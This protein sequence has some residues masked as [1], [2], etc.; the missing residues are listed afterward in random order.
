MKL[1]EAIQLIQ[2]KDLSVDTPVTWAD[3][4]CGSGTFTAALAHYLPAGSTIYAVDK[5]M[6][7]DLHIPAPSVVEVSPYQLDFVKHELPFAS[8]NGIIMANA[9]H[10]VKDQA[11]F[12]RKLQKALRPDGI[13]VM[14]EYDTDTPVPVWVPYPLSFTRLKKLFSA[15]GY[16]HI[17]K[18]GERPSIYGRANLY[19][20]LIK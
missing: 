3:L 20:S 1:Q 15:A 10:Y 14:V 19:A 2:H 5:A 4:G 18:I 9:L 7:P 16:G 6:S 17:E 13:L 12:V 8:L 11:A